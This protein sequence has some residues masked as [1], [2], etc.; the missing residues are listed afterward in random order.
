VSAWQ[1][2]AAASTNGTPTK[3]SSR[4]EVVI[5][6]LRK[7]GVNPTEQFGVAVHNVENAVQF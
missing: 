3:F 4:I 1:G 2:T 7:L 6:Y 5:A